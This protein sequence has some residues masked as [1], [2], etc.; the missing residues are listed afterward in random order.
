M[1]STV[2]NKEYAIGESWRQEG[3]QEIQREDNWG[4]KTIADSVKREIEIDEEEKPTS[5]SA[6]CR[7]RRNGVVSSTSVGQLGLPN[8]G[9]EDER[10]EEKEEECS[11]HISGQRRQKKSVT[12]SACRAINERDGVRDFKLDACNEELPNVTERSREEDK[13]NES[14]KIGCNPSAS[15]YKQEVLRLPGQSSTVHP[16]KKRRPTTIKHWL[17]DPNLYKV[18]L[19]K[20]IY[21]ATLKQMVIM[22]I[23]FPE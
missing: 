6:K 22:A 1:Q 18:C 3:I 11:S 10:S 13:E 23:K 2:V 16:A 4:N 5:V 21:F 7:E 20:Y 17:R 9:F 19:Y 15:E 12:F 14:V 8:F